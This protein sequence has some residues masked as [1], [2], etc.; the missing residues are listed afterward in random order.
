MSGNLPASM[1]PTTAKWI[2]LTSRLLRRGGALAATLTTLATPSIAHASGFVS[3]RYG[4][5]FGNPVGDNAYS[6]YFNPAAI[7]A[8][9]KT[10]VSLNAVLVYRLASYDRSA[11]S[12]SASFEKNQLSDAKTKA[13][14][15]KA[16]LG[17]GTLGNILASPFAGIVTDFGNPKLPIRAGLAVYV[18]FGG[19][20]SWDRFSDQKTSG[21][22]GG[23]DGPQRWSTISGK[24]TSLYITPALSVT[25]PGTGL[26]IGL[27][28]SAV[29]NTVQTV[30]ARNANGSDD[31]A[32]KDGTAIEG[33]SLIDVS[34]TNFT[35]AIGLYYEAIPK[36]LM[37][38]A[39]LSARPGFGQMR[40]KGTLRTQFGQAAKD[41]INDVELLQTYPDIWRFGLGY[42]VSDQ[43]MLRAD[44]N[45]VNWSVFKRQCLI[46]GKKD[47]KCSLFDNGAEASPE[48]VVIQSIA[49]D[50]K[51]A[52]GFR[53]SGSY[54]LSQ[55]TELFGSLG[56]DSSAVPDRTLD[57]TFIDADKVL[58][59]L[60][61]RQK[62]GDSFLL[63][64]SYNH[65]YFFTVDNKS[66]E[67]D[68]LEQD[69]KQPTTNGTYKQQ[70]FILD[71]NGTILF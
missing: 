19:Q 64:V 31:T 28:G 6:I 5:D 27:N 52:F 22:F 49:R 57:P 17:K 38:G 67:L 20:S 51:D 4:A 11:S 71:L 29:F 34:A 32:T 66:S 8:T 16:N 50:W 21:A 69:S 70:Y 23:V 7:A 55:A 43:V 68:K 65:V 59:S 36:K 48:N 13:D 33:R 60:G 37:F 12:P 15:D 47:A 63:G 18:P 61:V 40:L 9:E 62:F 10:Q 53:V 42:R 24:V 3:A 30:R 44:M 25:I 56:Y 45:Y 46:I 54:F 26:S 14:Y 58:G 41:A 1:S 39:S 35:G 2:N